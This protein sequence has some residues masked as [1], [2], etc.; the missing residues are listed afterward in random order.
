MPT[1][2]RKIITLD[3]LIEKGA[4]KDQ[5]DTFAEH[6]PEGLA[7]GAEH[8][9][10]LVERIGLLFDWEWAGYKL[11]PK[12]DLEAFKKVSNTAWLEFTKSVDPFLI[13]YNKGLD[14]AWSDYARDK[15]Y[16]EAYD[17][18]SKAVKQA[19]DKYFEEQEPFRAV[20]VKTKALAFLI[21]FLDSP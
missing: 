16:L 3:L 19:R 7:Y 12:Y 13:A 20:C 4:C 10:E 5:R 1:P 9:P 15:E 6:F 18:Y 11:L 14:K 17:D 21:L 2:L 8:I